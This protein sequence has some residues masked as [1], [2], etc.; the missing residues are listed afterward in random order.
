MFSSDYC[1]LI[2]LK[3]TRIKTHKRNFLGPLMEE[4]STM[5]PRILIIPRTLLSSGATAPP[6]ES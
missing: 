1:A 2:I 6:Q 4:K 5:A 3:I